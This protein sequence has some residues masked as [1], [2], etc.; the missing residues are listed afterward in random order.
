[1]IHHEQGLEGEEKS[2]GPSLPRSDVTGLLAHPRRRY[3]LE[4]LLAHGGSMGLPDLADE[5]AVAER[6]RSSARSHPRT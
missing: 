4:R 6:G 1:V 2:S 5:V 3:A